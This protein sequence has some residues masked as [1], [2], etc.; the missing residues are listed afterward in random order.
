[1]MPL[2]LIILC[3]LPILILF[4][5][6][7]NLGRTDEFFRL[8]IIV[9]LH[10]AILPSLWMHKVQN[11]RNF[12]TINWKKIFIPKISRKFGKMEI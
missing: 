5:H 12:A 9:K 3:T 10:F 2:V 1:M 8:D 11:F 7:R 4:L 6:F